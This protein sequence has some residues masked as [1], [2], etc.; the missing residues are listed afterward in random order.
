ME[1]FV[2]TCKNPAVDANYPS[3]GLICPDQH[4]SIQ[5]IGQPVRMGVKPAH[6]R[7]IEQEE[8][9]QLCIVLLSMID[10]DSCVEIEP[11]DRKVADKARR[12]R[13]QHYSTIKKIIE[14]DV[15]M[16]RQRRASWSW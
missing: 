13:S 10:P 11:L 1:S 7:P 12:F 15:N 16:Q 3:C 4:L 6:S 5:W 2:T 9:I 8:F 14:E